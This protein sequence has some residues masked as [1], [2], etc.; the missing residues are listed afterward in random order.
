MD[1]SACNSE[2]AATRV[3]IGARN[4]IDAT[5][6][7]PKKAEGKAQIEIIPETPTVLTDL[8]A[9]V[10][11]NGNVTYRWEKNGQVL[12]GENSQHLAK[13]N[14]VKGDRITVSA[15]SG[16]EAVSASVTIAN[17]RPRV[18]SVTIAPQY[19]YH[20]TDITATPAGFDADGDYVGFN[21]R[22]SI[23]GQE[24]SEREATLRGDKFKRGDVVSLDVTPYDYEG[25]GEVYHAVPFVIPNAPPRFVS[26]PPKEFSATTYEYQARAEDPDGDAIT[27]AISGAPT[28][29]TI[30]S[31]TGQLTWPINKEDVGEHTIE[32][33]AQ[34]DLG[35]KAVQK[36]T[37]TITI[38]REAQK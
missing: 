33:T 31:K 6:D 8:D 19:I 38:P 36:F 7:I 35:L 25:E 34:D 4:A 5:E 3:P 15:V 18:T 23:N 14:F 13:N 37:V 27:Y 29:M 10:S 32:I 21:Y 28:G 2:N 9:I 26:I 16:K 22:W 24:I 11:G 1:L 17:S 12:E 20:G 30:D